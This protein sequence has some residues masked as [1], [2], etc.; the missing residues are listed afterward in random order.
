M[1][2][3]LGGHHARGSG[4]AGLH[5]GGIGDVEPHRLENTTQVYPVRM[6]RAPADVAC[7]IERSLGVLGERWTFLILR[8]A[9]WGAT[10]F[11]DFQAALGIS[12]D[13]LSDRLATLVDAGVLE[14]RPYREPGERARS[15]YHVTEAGRELQVILGA[16]QQWGDERRPR[17][18]GPSVAR[19]RR[20]TGEP[21]AVAFVD[22]SGRAVGLDD[23]EFVRTCA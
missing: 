22:E 23:V 21:L 9:I 18:E 19:R 12:T 17:A 13:L 2:Y 8:E 15:G 20:S 1:A 5:L 7:S 14:K 11:R 3:S 16:L 6:P 4:Q 10:R